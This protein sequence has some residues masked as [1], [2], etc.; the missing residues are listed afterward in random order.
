MRAQLADALIASYSTEKA[1]SNTVKL[2]CGLLVDTLGPILATT[3]LHLPEQH[4][5]GEGSDDMHARYILWMQLP[6]VVFPST[7]PATSSS[8]SALQFA[9]LKKRSA[10]NAR[11][12]SAAYNDGR[13]QAHV[14]NFA[15][16]I[17]RLP[18]RFSDRLWL[19]AE[20]FLQPNNTCVSACRACFLH[21]IATFAF[22]ALLSTNLNSTIWI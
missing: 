2:R 17:L 5:N 6:S 19:K 14:G 10:H 20:I 11:R 16:R 1:S 4:R 15:L 18:A 21:F 7:T 22:G 13:Y 8:S 9:N 12:S 3:G